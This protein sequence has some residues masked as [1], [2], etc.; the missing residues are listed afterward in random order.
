MFP[1]GDR[2]YL[3]RAELGTG[4]LGLY[5]N[6]F[7]RAANIAIICMK[8]ILKITNRL[9]PA[10]LANNVTSLYQYTLSALERDC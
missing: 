2:G 1:E 8:K 10:R 5:G 4:S 7:R 9:L 6:E 3:E